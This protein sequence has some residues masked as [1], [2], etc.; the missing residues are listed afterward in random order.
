MKTLLFIPTDR[1]GLAS[2]QQSFSQTYTVI[3]E[4]LRKGKAVGWHTSGLRLPSTPLWPEGHYYQSGFSVPDEEDVKA[5]LDQNGLIY[6]ATTDLPE[7]QYHLRAKTI[8]LYN[9]RGAGPEFSGPLVEVLNMGGF[10]FSYISDAEIREGKLMNY[11]LFFVPGS[12]DAGEC[13]YTGLG[14]LGYEQIRRFIAERGHYIGVCGGAYFPLTSYQTT[15][16]YW[17]DVVEATDTEDLDYWRTGSGFVRCRVDCDDHPVFSGIAVGSSTTMNLV[18]W[19]GPA[20]TIK[21]SNIRPLA[22]FE[23]LIG[24][25]RGDLRPSWDMF[26]NQMAAEASLKYYNPLTEENFNKILRNK[27]A[28]AEGSYGK[29]KLLLYSPHPE[30]G[31][32]GYGPRKDSLNFL[33]LYNG[34]F[35][36]SAD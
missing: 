35:Y 29:H 34:L 36:L 3:N 10:Q 24:T 14:D 17:L 30:M 32:I 1:V 6:C 25:A 31:N 9:G 26:D 12:P 2:F 8:A 4:L 28:V 13:Y 11:D 19:E 20:I 15:N 21:G 27:A 18:Y 23:A 22:H 16:P 33:L 7:P 5:L